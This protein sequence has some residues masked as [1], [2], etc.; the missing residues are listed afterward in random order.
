MVLGFEPVHKP[1]IPRH[2]FFDKG[3][4]LAL[5]GMFSGAVKFV[6]VGNRNLL[7]YP[8]E[9]RTRYKVG[10]FVHLLMTQILLHKIKK[11]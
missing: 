11:A 5:T 3:H 7:R 9:N 6:F 4:F 8:S 1:I 2:S 10:E